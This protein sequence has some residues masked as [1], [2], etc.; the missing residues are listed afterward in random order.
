MDPS[1]F[2]RKPNPAPPPKRDE[3][4]PAVN[5]KHLNSIC[6]DDTDPS[7]LSLSP[8]TNEH[9]HECY[10]STAFFVREG[11][12]GENKE[13]L[14]F[15][16]VE[17]GECFLHKLR[18]PIRHRLTDWNECRLDLEAAAEPECVEGCGAQDRGRQIVR[19]LSRVLVPGKLP[20]TFL[21]L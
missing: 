13:M 6:D 1:L 21:D 5:G 10:D 4:A 11:L 20:R 18:G 12:T 7:T 9:D 14:F 3:A 17:P 16:D 19:N 8:L 15:G 2:H